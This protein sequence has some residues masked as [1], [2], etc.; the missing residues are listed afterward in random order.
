[1]QKRVGSRSRVPVVRRCALCGEARA[2]VP[3][4]EEHKKALVTRQ[5]AFVC[6]DCADLVRIEVESA[7]EMTGKP[8]ASA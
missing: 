4:N 2:I 6:Q 1:M 3:I 8:R 7:G 5:V